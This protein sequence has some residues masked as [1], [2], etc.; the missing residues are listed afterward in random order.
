[1]M[2]HKTKWLKQTENKQKPGKVVS[3]KNDKTFSR[4]N[5]AVEQRYK[6]KTLPARFPAFVS[7]RRK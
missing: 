7:R 4:K 5:I 3:V 2:R 1:M 6:L